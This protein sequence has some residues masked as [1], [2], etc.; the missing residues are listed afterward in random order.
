MKKHHE[1]LE[2]GSF[3]SETLDIFCAKRYNIRD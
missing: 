2:K 3:S 1:I